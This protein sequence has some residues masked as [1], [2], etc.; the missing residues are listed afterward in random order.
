MKLKLGVA[1]LLLVGFGVAG[2][3]ALLA[4][5]SAA[6]E[7][8]EFLIEVEPTG[9]GVNLVCRKGC[10]WKQ[11]SFDCGDRLPCRS[12]VNGWGMTEGTE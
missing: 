10:A 5:E 9:S 1:L 3:H 4:A 6:V 8:A 12:G 2:H 7:P 11:L